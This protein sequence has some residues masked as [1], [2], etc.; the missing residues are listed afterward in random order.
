MHLLACGSRRNN[1]RRAARRRACVLK[2]ARRRQALRDGAAAQ[3]AAAGQMAPLPLRPPGQPMP[4]GAPPPGARP[5]GPPMMAPRGRRPVSRWWRR[6]A[7]ARPADGGAWTAAGRRAADGLT[8]M[9]VGG[10]PR[11][12]PPGECRGCARALRGPRGPPPK[13]AT[14]DATRRRRSGSAGA[15]P[16]MGSPRW[17][18]RRRWAGRRRRSPRRWADVDGGPP[19]ACRRTAGCPAPAPALVPMSGSTGGRAG[20]RGECTR[21]ARRTRRQAAAAAAARPRAAGPQFS[22]PAQQAAGGS[23]APM[24]GD[25]SGRN[26]SSNRIDPAQSRGPRRTRTRSAERAPTWG[27]CRRP[28]PRASSSG[29]RQLLAAFMAWSTSSSRPTRTWRRV[30]CRS[31]S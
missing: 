19:V 3:C 26:S 1:F 16:P 15:A 7:A 18:S 25:D 2:W 10:P 28:P 13:W 14:A 20:R 24:A 6:A 11:G 21:R 12:P 5:G 9:G 27:R 23:G 22:S 29:R 4:M 30:P 17:A 8:A 31:A